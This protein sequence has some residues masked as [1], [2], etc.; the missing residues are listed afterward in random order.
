MKQN[1]QLENRMFDVVLIILIIGAV[2][3]IITNTIIGL[4][5]FINIKWVVLLTMGMLFRKGIHYPKFEYK[6]NEAY[7]AWRGCQSKGAPGEAKSIDV[8]MQGYVKVKVIIE[9]YQEDTQ[10]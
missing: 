8:Y 1:N 3:S 5:L 6:I 4:P 9:P 10:C 7:W 2:L